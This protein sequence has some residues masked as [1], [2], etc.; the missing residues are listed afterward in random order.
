MP[1][2]PRSLQIQ[3][4]RTLETGQLVL[5]RPAIKG[6][7]S[8]VHLFDPEALADA[9]RDLIRPWAPPIASASLPSWPRKQACLPHQ[10][11]I[12]KNRRGPAPACGAGQRRLASAARISSIRVSTH[13]SDPQTKVAPPKKKL[14]TNPT[15]RDFR[16]PKFLPRFFKKNRQRRSLNFWPFLAF[17]RYYRAPCA[18]APGPWTILPQ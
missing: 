4:L 11:A 7:T 8:S 13:Q 3:L 15:L 14:V 10:A 12:V 2:L 16:T 6:V 17:S 1:F 5:A 18:F 9:L